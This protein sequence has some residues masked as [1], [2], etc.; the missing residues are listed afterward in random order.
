MPTRK[1]I[2]DLR[3]PHIKGLPER[4]VHLLHH[5]IV[6]IA[7]MRR[8]IEETDHQVA[9]SEKALEQSRELLKRLQ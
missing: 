7:R 9:L 6:Q 1:Q 2:K 4:D 8:S 5:S 3:C